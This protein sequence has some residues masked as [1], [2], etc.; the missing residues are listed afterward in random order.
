MKKSKAM[1][2]GAVFTALSTLFLW[3]GN[4][5]ETLDAGLAVLGSLVIFVALIEFKK[6]LALLV[7][8]ASSVLSLLLNPVN[9]A[10]WLFL[11]FLGWYPVFKQ[12]IEQI[13]Y[14]FAWCVKVSAFNVS[15]FLYWLVFTKVLNLPFEETGILLVALWL[16]GNLVFILY[17]LLMTRMITLYIFRWRKLLGFRD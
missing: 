13:H 17:D 2:F 4:V 1:A 14:V 9:S 16:G 8:L 12:R 7:W 15:A 3:A 10:A 11:L 5:I 6:G